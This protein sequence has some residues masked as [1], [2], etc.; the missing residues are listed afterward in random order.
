MVAYMQDLIGEHLAEK[1]YG[2]EAGW[3]SQSN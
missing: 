2:D 1:R 3:Q